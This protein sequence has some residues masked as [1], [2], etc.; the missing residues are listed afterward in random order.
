MSS[1]MTQ[2]KVSPNYGNIEIRYPCNVL[3]SSAF[4]NYVE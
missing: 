4:T 2:K 3:S 1:M